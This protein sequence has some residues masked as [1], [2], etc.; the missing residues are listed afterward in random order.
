MLSSYRSHCN[1]LTVVETV[2]LALCALQN[3]ASGPISLSLLEEA[4]ESQAQ[5]QVRTSA[6]PPQL[7]CP[8]GAVTCRPKPLSQMTIE[9][10]VT[11]RLDL[12]T[13]VRWE[14]GICSWHD[15]VCSHVICRQAAAVRDKLVI[16]CSCSPGSPALTP[17]GD[18]PH[19]HLPMYHRFPAE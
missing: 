10:G 8:E 14:V 11:A 13:V 2:H 12:H 1:A 7:M 16:V 18:E 17:Q 6:L 5:V 15:Q 9:Q 19:K 4:R 3:S